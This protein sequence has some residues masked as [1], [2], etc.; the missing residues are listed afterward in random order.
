MIALRVKACLVVIVTI[1]VTACSNRPA[2]EPPLITPP[3]MPAGAERWQEGAL[4]VPAKSPA[5]ITARIDLVLDAL[6]RLKAWLVAEPEMFG[7]DG[8]RI[9]RTIETGWAAATAYLGVDP[10]LDRAW[11]ERGVDPSRPIFVGAYPVQRDGRRV[12]SVVETVLREDLAIPPGDPVAPSLRRLHYEGGSLPQGTHARVMRALEE[13]TPL[14]GVRV[15][16]GVTSGSEFLTTATSFAEG[17]GFRVFP[18][19]LVADRRGHLFWS[20]T[21]VSAMSIR[22]AGDW[23]VL[24]L[25][26]PAF[27]S[28]NGT[29]AAKNEQLAALIASLDRAMEEVP[30]GRASAPAPPGEPTLSIS[31]DQ[32]SM[33][34]FVR[35]VGYKDDL[36]AVQT[37]STTRRDADLLE[38]LLDTA[39]DAESWDE[40]SDRLTGTTFHVDVNPVGADTFGLAQMTLFARSGLPALDTASTRPTLQ[41]SKRSSALGVD[42]DMLRQPTWSAWVGESINEST[43]DQ[44]FDAPTPTTDIFSVLRRMALSAMN[45]EELEFSPYDEG[46]PIRLLSRIDGLQRMEFVGLGPQLPD[47]EKSPE[48]LV[49][50]VLEPGATG[51]TVAKL[52]QGLREALAAWTGLESDPVF[53]PLV[54]GETSV[55]QFAHLPIQQHMTDGTT[56]TVLF[57]IGVAESEFR[58]EIG[59]LVTPRLVDGALHARI[60]PIALVSWLRDDGGKIAGD[61]DADILSQRLG[62]L[63][64]R[65]SGIQLGDTNAMSIEV[66][67]EV[68]A[69]L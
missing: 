64:L 10:L 6:T 30:S 14:I 5:V 47:L 61:L 23:A 67:L 11:M 26:F 54:P 60:G 56:P 57:G 15:V 19:A 69:D 42:L 18:N 50:A 25:L 53:E 32:A 33:S 17:F 4:L 39:S 34:Q 13:T 27:D 68:P 24:D 37:V 36:E 52:Q 28:G 29:P 40:A 21:E 3:S 46:S 44:Q 31:F 48:V 62:A 43:H 59:P 66:A 38:L 35:V 12:V 55:V 63:S 41:L 58:R 22:L 65:C 16:V 8:P 45:F 49:A 9:V 7:E 1:G 51:E 20:E 2:A